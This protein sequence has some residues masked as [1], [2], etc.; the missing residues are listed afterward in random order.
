MPTTG[1]PGAGRPA[2]PDRFQVPLGQ[3][4]KNVQAIAPEEN[5]RRTGRHFFARLPIPFLKNRPPAP[6]LEFLSM[7]GGIAIARLLAASQSASAACW[8]MN[9]GSS[10]GN[11]CSVDP[12]AGKAKG[13]FSRRD[14]DARA[15]SQA[16]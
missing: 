14:F 3:P 1:E 5:R 8:R 12:L 2:I 9:F 13:I 4:L 11:H 15:Q 16:W 7:F 10:T 6:A